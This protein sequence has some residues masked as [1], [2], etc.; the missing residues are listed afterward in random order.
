MA[1]L[2]EYVVGSSYLDAIQEGGWP[3]DGDGFVKIPNR[4]GLGVELDPDG[5]R[6]YTRDARELLNV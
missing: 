5:L 6:K 2:A 4:S 3:L 1:N